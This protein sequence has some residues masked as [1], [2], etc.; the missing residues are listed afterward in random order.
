M[1][2]RF[3]FD[4]T[5]VSRQF[6]E[7]L[8]KVSYKHA[9]H[10]KFARSAKFLVKKFKIEEITGLSF[11][12]AISLIEDFIEVYSLNLLY[13][14]EFKNKNKKA[15]FLPHCA[16][17]YMDSRCK[18]IFDPSISSY[19]CQSCSEDCLI[20]KATKLARSKGYDV[21]VVPGGSCIPKIIAKYKYE[22]VVG[23]AC[24]MEL[25][26]AASLLKNYNIPGQGVPL[27]KNGCANTKFNI[28]ELEKALI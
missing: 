18:A 14:N 3:N 27:I 12:D 4:L 26:L 25:K 20:N 22:A 7:D 19:F 6:F 10:R 8:V 5:N 24:T 23:V 1:P 16:R 17:K 13:R 28:D 15:V 11:S 21:Y 2:Y 9:L